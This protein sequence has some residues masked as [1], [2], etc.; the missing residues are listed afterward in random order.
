VGRAAEV[1]ADL[2]AREVLDDVAG[3]GQRAG[4]AVELGDDE[5]VPR[6]AGRE[7]FAQSGRSRC[8]PVRPWST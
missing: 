5:R 6:A 1:E 2:A 4:E 3:V 7:G 8:L